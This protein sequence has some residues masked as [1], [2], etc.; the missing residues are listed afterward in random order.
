VPMAWK[1]LSPVASGRTAR[2]I[3]YLGDRNMLT[4][5]DSLFNRIMEALQAG[6][7]CARSLHCAAAKRDQKTIEDVMEVLHDL[8]HIQE[9]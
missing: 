6:L 4:M 1:P 2:R 5:T 8:D 7:E 9:P 3:L